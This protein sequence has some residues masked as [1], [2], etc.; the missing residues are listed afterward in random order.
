MPIK[1]QDNRKYQSMT[2]AEADDLYLRIARLKASIDKETAAHKAQLAELELA[3]KNRIAAAL[4][5]KT[6]L[7]KELTAYIL[8]N[9]GRFVKP[10]KRSVG[11]IGAYGLATDPA[12]V[13]IVDA[14]AAVAYALENGY[15]DLLRVTR[16]VEKEAVLR[17]AAA[18]ETIP[19]I[20][21]VGA[22]D[23]AKLT[24]RKGYAEA[25]EA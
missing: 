14:D 20:V 13:R 1:L 24:F 10:R 12:Y 25:L 6:A 7:E 17:H 4:E 9:P 16:E 22:G 11:A 2:A 23:V 8:A 3:H 19:G 21:V 5:E 18:G 15:E